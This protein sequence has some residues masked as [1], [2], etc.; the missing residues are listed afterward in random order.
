MTHA[1]SEGSYA[2]NAAPN[3][4]G[5]S[6]TSG[7]P[8]S[9]NYLASLYGQY[10]STMQKNSSFHATGS[11]YKGFDDGIV[12][13]WN[14]STGSRYIDQQCG[15][16]WLTTFAI[17]NAAFTKKAPESI[18]LVTWD[19]YEEGT[20]METGISNCLNNLDPSISGSVLSWKPTFGTS[21]DG[22]TG[23]ENTVS[24]YEVFVSLDGSSLMQLADVPAPTHS[25]D[26]SKASLPAGTYKVYI[27][28]VG[29]PML[30]NYFTPASV[31]YTATSSTTPAH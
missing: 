27:E 13:G 8:F 25:Y 28:A 24:S 3:W 4:A 9:F 17:A 23:S 22:V 11:V 29:K 5:Y 31:S 12:D 2:W 7:D 16:T 26:L 21:F 30:S 18:W 15:Q 10:A 19:D 6:L 14:A 1:L 20:E